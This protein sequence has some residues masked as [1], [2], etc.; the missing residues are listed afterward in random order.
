MILT[1]GNKVNW[2]VDDLNYNPNAN[3]KYTI[4]ACWHGDVYLEVVL[5][6]HTLT[7]LCILLECS[8]D[9]FQNN[10]GNGNSH[11]FELELN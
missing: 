3:E 1:E 9:V 7:Y 6:L 11:D 2:D 10:M 8:R 5:G 4:R